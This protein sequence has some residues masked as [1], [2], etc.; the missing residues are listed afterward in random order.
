MFNQIDNFFVFQECVNAPCSFVIHEVDVM[1][2]IR[3][4][5]GLNLSLISLK[6]CVSLREFNLL[7]R[8]LPISRLKKN[9]W[10]VVQSLIND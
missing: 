8:P 6:T 10:N 2:L 7:L 1:L 9:H 4:H 3:E 5:K